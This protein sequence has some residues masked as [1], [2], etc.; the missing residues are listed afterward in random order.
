MV[1]HHFNRIIRNKWIWGV[2]AVAISVFFAF[3]F[4]F[5]GREFPSATKEGREAYSALVR[6]LASEV[7]QTVR[8]SSDDPVCV[9]AITYAVYGDVAYFL[10]MDTRR[11]RKFVYEAGGRRSPMELGPCEIRKVN[12]RAGPGRGMRK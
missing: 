5:T 6:R 1:I 7:A 9:N 2:F 8:I 11:A 12:L 4:L 10:N 3:D